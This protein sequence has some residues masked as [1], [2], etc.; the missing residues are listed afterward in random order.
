M[1][2]GTTSGRSSRKMGPGAARR[3]NCRSVNK[4]EGR[5][6]SGLR[7]WDGS[8]WD[9]FFGGLL[10]ECVR[11]V[12]CKL[13][14]V[15]LREDGEVDLSQVAGHDRD[16]R[17]GYAVLDVFT[18]AELALDKDRIGLLEAAGGLSQLVPAFH[19]EP[20]GRLLLLFALRPR[21]VDRDAEACDMFAAG[22]LSVDGIL[23]EVAFDLNEVLHCNSPCVCSRPVRDT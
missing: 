6:E 4:G 14:P 13:G 3:H 2:S 9:R 11:A 22:E 15:C 7:S 23:S 8:V 16:C 10:F 21:L 18:G 20:V 12:C 5:S 19:A 1:L 17:D